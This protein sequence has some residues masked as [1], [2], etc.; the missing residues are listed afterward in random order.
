LSRDERI[1]L[2]EQAIA[3]ILSEEPNL[4]RT[5]TNHPGYDLFEQGRE[6][7]AVRY[8]EVKAMKADLD[9][10][11]VGMSKKQFESA[12]A[13]RERYWLYVVERADTSEAR[14]IRINDPAGKARTFTFDQGWT[15]I[16]EPAPAVPAAETA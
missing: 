7:E 12:W 13:L 1:A 4:Q 10:R 2:E 15:N 5:P 3:L 11:P 16:A 6:E 9:A 14:I 8:V